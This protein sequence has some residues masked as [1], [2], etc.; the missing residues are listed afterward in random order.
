[1]TAQ[2]TEIV[3]Y[4]NEDYPLFGL[5][6][7][8][9]IKKHEEIKFE[10]Y[11]RSNWRG[12]QGYW[13][14]END[15][16]YLNNIRSANYSLLDLFGTTDPV[17]AEW[18]SGTLSIGFGQSFF[19]SIFNTYEDYFQMK[20]ENGVIVEKAIIK[21]QYQDP[22]FE[23]GK[24]KGREVNDVINGKIAKNTYT[25][26]K[27]FIEDLVEGLSNKECEY[28]IMCHSFNLTEDDKSSIQRIRSNW[29]KIDFFITQSYIAVSSK[30]FFDH[31]I[32]D[33]IAEEAS[34]I[35]EKILKSN[36]NHLVSFSENTV[37][38]NPDVQ[39]VAWAISN[40]ETF[41][42][43]PS[44]LRKQM[45][46]K[47]IRTLNV[48]RLNS[49]V[50]EYAPVIEVLECAFSDELIKLNQ[51]KFE[52]ANGVIYDSIK[53]A[54]TYNLSEEKMRDR[55]G[56]FLCEDYKEEDF[57]SEYEDDYDHRHW[58]EDELEMGDWDY[59]PWNPA[60][61][62]GENPWIDVFGAG[63]EAEA[64]YWNTD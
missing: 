37:L 57:E 41:S 54:Y 14:I 49:F 32:K 30:T 38:I 23:F 7:L 19:D 27:V 12:Y 44:Y 20:I 58:S 10:E 63:E 40:V 34:R 60:H 15:R 36:F 26:I 25:T 53:N 9:Y 48:N 59:D 42:V 17:F 62:P 8:E 33:E 3:K 2:V 1:M 13:L 21:G 11:G 28:D 55:F 51:E 18:Y 31:L 46:L 24:Y 56:Y 29:N 22:E 61:D 52:K 45:S 35:L 4:R 64:A 47:K 16:L 39:Y 5:P 50:F 43:P 6:L